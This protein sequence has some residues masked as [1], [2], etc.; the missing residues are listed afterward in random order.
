[1]GIT[2]EQAMTAKK[3]GRSVKVV[4]QQGPVKQS[5]IATITGVHIRPK[6]AV[7]LRGRREGEPNSVSRSLG[8]M[9]LEWIFLI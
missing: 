4:E 9:G 1:M 3:S 2:L 6:E 5:Y 8:I 7:S